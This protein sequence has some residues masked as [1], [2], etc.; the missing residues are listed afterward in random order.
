MWASVSFSINSY[1]TWRQ[2]TLTPP[3][4]VPSLKDVD[5]EALGSTCFPTHHHSTITTHE[6]QSSFELAHTG[7]PKRSRFEST[8]LPFGSWSNNL[9]KPD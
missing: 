2:V 7:E 1:F 4:A 8:R 9:N 3:L 5:G 6:Q